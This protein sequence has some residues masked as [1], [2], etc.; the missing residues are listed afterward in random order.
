V[1][2]A[3]LE[4]TLLARVFGSFLV[5]TDS[6]ASATQVDVITAALLG[7]VEH[8]EALFDNA[9]PSSSSSSS[10]SSTWAASSPRRSKGSLRSKSKRSHRKGRSSM[11]PSG[12]PVKWSA[13]D[14]LSWL[15]AVECSRAA[16]AFE[17][18]KITGMDLLEL[19]ANELREDLLIEDEELCNQLL[20]RIALLR[21]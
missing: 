8:F 18:N 11:M 3:D 13:K 6:Y 10:S 5:E 4:K 16:G 14:V 7:C 1:A 9:S 12:K 15:T 2:T 19:S 20:D 21:Q 17:E